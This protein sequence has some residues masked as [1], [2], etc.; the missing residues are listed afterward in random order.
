MLFNS[1]HKI[2]IF[3]VRNIRLLGP[4]HSIFFKY[5]SDPQSTKTYSHILQVISRVG[6]TDDIP[7]RKISFNFSYN[8][9]AI[10]TLQI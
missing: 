1:Y 9:T 7:E 5:P 10:A 4:F 6:T 8:I 3:A 2:I